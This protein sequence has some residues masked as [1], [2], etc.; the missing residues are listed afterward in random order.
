MSKHLDHIPGW[1]GTL[2]ELA[3]AVEAMSYDKT[4]EFLTHLATCFSKRSAIDREQG[5]HNLA[6]ALYNAFTR[7]V[8]VASYVE[9]AWNI[10]KPFMGK[11]K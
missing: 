3:I 2:E 11:S 6:N 10:C 1:P 4:L 7:T 9:D 5:R 8:V